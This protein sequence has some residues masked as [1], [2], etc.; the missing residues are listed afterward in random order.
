MTPQAIDTEVLIVGAGP[1]G[2]MLA[3]LL[4]LYGH[5]AT[6]LEQLPELI[7]YPRGVGIDDES[8]RSVQTTG[9]SDT[10]LPH[11]TAQHIMRLVNGRGKVIMTNEPKADEFG[12]PRKNGF[13]QPLVDKALHEGLQR[14]PRVSMHF[15]HRVVDVLETAAG[16]TA[17]VEVDNGTGTPLTRQVRAKYIVGCEGGK[18]GTRKRMGVSFEGQSPSTRWLV[19]DV[20]NDP[21][22]TPNVFLGADPKRPYVSIGLAHAIRRWEFMIFDH[23][24]DAQVMEKAF[25]HG[26][27]KDHVPDPSA[28]EI[29]RERVFTHHGRIAGSFRKGR[30]LI[31]GDAAHLMPVWM[32]QGW[33]SA[34]RDATNLAWKLATVLRGDADERL[35]DS[36]D[37][38]RRDHAK[39]MID[40]SLTLGNIIK[41][42]NPFVVAGRDAL[43]AALNLFPTVKSYFS[44]MRFKPMP[45]YTSGVVVDPTTFTPGRAGATLTGRL[46]PTRTSNNR[47]SPVG[48]QF[49]QPLVAT[50]AHPA[51]RLDDAVGSWWTVLAWGNNPKGMF[52]SADL[53]RLESLGAAFV[54]AVPESQRT[55]AESRYPSDV[56]VVGD[57]TGALKAWFDDRPTPVLFLRPDRFVAA[58]SLAQ[59]APRALH[60][61]L[62]ALSF[63]EG[64]TDATRTHLHVA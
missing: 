36:Y 40:L 19:V 24:T 54:A 59:D 27:L 1:A 30:C 44:D 33:N 14:F 34:V 32:G 61:I 63:T 39:A 49:I 56:V 53:A 13:V 48:V 8:L 28:L 50:K 60:A 10:V 6:L 57:T 55:W 35:L 43:A 3:N 16:V 15:N 5:E 47:T 42:T 22:G 29:I 52:N 20:E 7:D 12:W 31:A 46:I 2:L 17:T 9:L 51:L 62:H 26:L 58:A 11:T 23:E 4:G 37:A 64:A 45:R 41:P 25:I 18:S 21:L 38:E